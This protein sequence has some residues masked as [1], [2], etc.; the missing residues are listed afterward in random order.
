MNVPYS[1]FGSPG[2]EHWGHPL[3]KSLGNEGKKSKFGLVS[4]LV[5]PRD[6]VSVLACPM[7]ADSSRYMKAACA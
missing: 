4:S 6:A 1:V 7:A 3:T 2:R 5:A